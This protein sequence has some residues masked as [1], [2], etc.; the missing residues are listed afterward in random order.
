MCGE[1]AN[2]CVFM[3]YLQQNL[4]LYKKLY[5]NYTYMSV[6]A[7]K[8]YTIYRKEKAGNGNDG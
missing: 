6:K 3:T 5:A 7:A 8:S 2:V 4:I 1:H